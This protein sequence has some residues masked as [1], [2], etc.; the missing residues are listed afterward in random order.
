MRITVLYYDTHTLYNTPFTVRV[1]R[2][3]HTQSDNFLSTLCYTQDAL[4]ACGFVTE[5]QHVTGCFVFYV[6]WKPSCS[7]R[8]DGR[9][10]M[11]K[12][13]IAFRNFDNA[14]KNA[15][16]SFA[17]AMKAYRGSRGMVPLIRNLDIR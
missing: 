7:T 17:A 2:K 5:K 6:Q 11:T 1:E 16:L 4:R 12:L 3:C 8:T 10:D 14:P 13:K 15:S 9:T